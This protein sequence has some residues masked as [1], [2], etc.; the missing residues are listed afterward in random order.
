MKSQ[1]TKTTSPQQLTQRAIV[2]SYHL[3]SQHRSVGSTNKVTYIHELDCKIL[4]REISNLFFYFLPRNSLF[5]YL[6]ISRKTMLYGTYWSG[7]GIRIYASSFI[8]VKYNLILFMFWGINF[9]V[10]IFPY[11]LTKRS[12]FCSK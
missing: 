11:I 5:V 1:T 7:F 8:F 3:V 6:N 4:C 2:E 9:K 10:I 12:A